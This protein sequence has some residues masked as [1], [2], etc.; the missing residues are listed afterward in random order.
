MPTAYIPEPILN[1]RIFYKKL[2]VSSLKKQIYILST[3]ARQVSPG[4]P[5]PQDLW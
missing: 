3:D 5:I 4:S 1:L 2:Y